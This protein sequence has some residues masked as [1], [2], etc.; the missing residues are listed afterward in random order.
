MSEDP[1][2]ALEQVRRTFRT[3]D[4]Q[5]LIAVDVPSLVVPGGELRVVVG[6]NGSGKTTLLHLVAGL[7]R[8]DSGTVRVDGQ[9]LG[10]LS[11]PALDRFRATRIGYLLQGAPLL[12][13]LAAW[14][15]VAAALL[16][17]GQRGRAARDRAH[18][19]LERVGVGHRAG[20][21]PH[22][23]SG[24]ERQRVALARALALDPPV[25]LADEPLASLDGP[26]VEQVTA[27]LR[28][29]AHGEGKAVIVV[30]H[31]PDELGPDAQVLELPPARLDEGEGT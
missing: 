24:G 19:M 5:R 15:N 4:R 1:L 30:T 10:A 27:E 20:H 25:I 9:E 26:S 8:P 14:E 11:E 7:L 23:L 18:S 16:F 17:A 13:G 21:R 2:V 29:L 12:D 3:P 6:P 22:A 28:R 31:R